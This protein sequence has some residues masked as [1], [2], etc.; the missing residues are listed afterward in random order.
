VTITLQPIGFVRSPRTTLED[1]HWGDVISTIELDAAFPIESLDGIET[2]SHAEIIFLFDQIPE[3]SIV[4]GSRHPRDNPDWPRIGI[5]AQRGAVRPN[6]MG[7]TIVR[8][9]GREGRTLRVQG[10]DAV[11]GTPVLD[12][13]PVMAEF[14]PRD[15]VGQPTWSHE[16]MRNYW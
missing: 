15:L 4:T 8:V 5:F 11:D 7:A 9:L 14:L 10:L 12:I 3:S 2:F 16:V 13:K 1:D 6:R